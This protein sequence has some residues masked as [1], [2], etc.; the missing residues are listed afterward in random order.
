MRKI[1][2]IIAF[3][4]VAIGLPAAII[5]KG[6]NGYRDGDN[7]ELYYLDGI[8][9]VY[10]DSNIYDFSLCKIGDI[11]LQKISQYDDS[12]LSVYENRNV[13]I[14]NVKGDSLMLLSHRQPGIN[15]RYIMPEIQ[16]K[17]PFCNGDK[18]IGNFY[19]EGIDGTSGYLRH[20]GNYI[21]KASGEGKLVTPD[22]DTIPD[23]LMT[24]YVRHGATV[25]ETDFSNS[26][27]RT[28]DSS[29]ISTG[30]I[31]YKII[32]DSITHR[33]IRQCWY[34]SGYRYPIVDIQHYLTYYYGIQN[35]SVTIALYH[36][37]I[38]QRYNLPSDSENEA[39]RSENQ[40]GSGMNPR[41]HGSP[42]TKSSTSIDACPMTGDNQDCDGSESMDVCTDFMTQNRCEVYPT[43][44]SNS[45]TI[46]LNLCETMLIEAILYNSSGKAVWKND[47]KY[48]SGA[49]TI[50]CDMSSLADGNYLMNVAIGKNNYSY[51][52]VKR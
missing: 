37:P 15:L 3:V 50:D 28:R 8:K 6:L 9:G 42:S 18:I 40:F 33:V 36:S 11:Y 46:R 7:A 39:I 10:H 14:Y 4:T 5:T 1:I 52:L 26:F 34:A 17:Y 27:L 43:D 20:C 35:D 12:L 21:I 24:T 41:T 13:N 49:Y 25:T 16:M 2:L 30:T 38:S 31:N 48:S 51:K 23:V 32:T 45:T 44:V 19:A 22:G 29:M 47:S